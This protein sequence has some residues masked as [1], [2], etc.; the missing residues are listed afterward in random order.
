MFDPDDAG[1]PLAVAC[2]AC[3]SIIDALDGEAP[4]IVQRIN[5]AVSTKAPIQRF[6]EHARSR[7]WRNV[8]LL[9][10]A[11]T[12]Y[13]HD[14]HTESPDDKQDPIATVFVRHDGKIHHFWSSELYW[15]PTDSGQ[16]F[17]HVDFMWPPWNV[18]DRTPDGRGSDWGPRLKYGQRSPAVLRQT[19]D[20]SASR[21][22]SFISA[23]V[24]GIAKIVSSSPIFSPQRVS[25]IGTE[26]QTWRETRPTTVDWLHKLC[27]TVTTDLSVTITARNLTSMNSRK[28]MSG[29]M[30]GERNV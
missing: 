8:R 16:H 11:N 15:V 28:P 4:H 6:R 25:S 17:R 19:T 20:R 14:Y 26:P 13:N 7:G 29:K 3:T 18:F 21:A 9:S 30:T 10:C 24:V 23:S 12:T 22:A 27:W 1:Q 5:L 2:P